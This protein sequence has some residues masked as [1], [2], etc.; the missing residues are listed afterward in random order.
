MKA[1]EAG[2]ALEEV[3]AEPDLPVT[4]REQ[5]A[6]A[7]RRLEE[8]E[9]SAELMARAREAMQQARASRARPKQAASAEPA[10]RQ[11]PKEPRRYSVRAFLMTI[12]ETDFWWTHYDPEEIGQALTAEQWA[13]F[14]EWITQAAV[15]H[16]AAA[17]ARP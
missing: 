17:A 7:L 13:Q 16:K 4:L 14:E 2:L 15:F 8:A 10:V 9:S 1:A 11:A 12:Q 6:R 5:T 3:L